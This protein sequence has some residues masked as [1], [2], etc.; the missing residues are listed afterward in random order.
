[1]TMYV[2]AVHDTYPPIAA[3]GANSIVAHMP[4]RH[5]RGLAKLP[6]DLRGIRSC[7]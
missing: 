6:A 7:M 4:N 5:L 2:L 1:M 3:G